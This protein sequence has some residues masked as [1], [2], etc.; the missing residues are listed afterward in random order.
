[1]SVDL[2]INHEFL[3]KIKLLIRDKKF[4]KLFG[5]ISTLHPADIATIIANLQLEESI[6]LEAS[7]I[8]LESI[9]N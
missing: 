5:I 2:I 1:M 3:K 9:F 8:D 6:I 4:K 7:K